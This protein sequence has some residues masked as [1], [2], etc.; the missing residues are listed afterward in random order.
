M[1]DFPT[2]PLGRRSLM[3][4]G[5][6]LVLARGTGAFATS[7]GE[8]ASLT[9]FLASSET[10]AA[11]LPAANRARQDAYV[12]AAASRALTA[13]PPSLPKM[14]PM[15][16]FDGVEI[17]PGGKPTIVA[18]TF[19]RLAPGA[20]LPAHD[21]PSYSVATIGLTGEVAV[22]QFEVEGDMPPGSARFAVRE[23]VRTLLRPGSVATL[24]PSRDNIHTFRAGP[25]GATFV[26]LSTPHGEQNDFTY[27]QIDDAPRGGSDRF[28]AARI[29][30]KSE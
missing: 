3:L 29:S 8:P 24:S 27:L 30:F 13:A 26:D 21:H 9:E 11:M 25:Q 4:M 10:L 2:A 1:I 23:T 19:Y 12:L 14:Y 7:G 22:R 28:G 16:P 18:A 5:G 15:T 6:A 20:V 17:G